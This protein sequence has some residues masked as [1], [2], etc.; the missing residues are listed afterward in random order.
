MKRLQH[1]LLLTLCLAIGSM[2]LTGCGGK[3]AAGNDAT[4]VITVANSPDEVA[5]G[6]E[7]KTPLAQ[8]S[9]F[10]FD[11]ETLTYTFTGVE[12]AEFYYIRT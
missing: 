1:A 6:D 8:V 10:T 11:F 5:A 7:S 4:G 2:C 3:K 9:D 12:N